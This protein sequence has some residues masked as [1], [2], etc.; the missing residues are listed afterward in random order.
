MHFA[1]GPQHRLRP[2]FFYHS[3]GAGSSPP[4]LIFLARQITVGR[5]NLVRIEGVCRL[6]LAR[7]TVFWRAKKF[8]KR[9]ELPAP[10]E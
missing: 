3:K 7:P 6:K 5:A 1:C 2:T 8:K 10:F 9:G 4:F